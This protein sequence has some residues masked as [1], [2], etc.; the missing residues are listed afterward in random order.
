KVPPFPMADVRRI[1]ELELG[2]QLESVFDPF[3]PVPIAAA[4]LGQVHRAT[5]HG[6]VVAIKVLRPN[7]ER[8]VAA[9]LRIMRFML[10]AARLVYGREV[11]LQNIRNLVSE[12]SRV[13]AAEM[14]FETE[15]ANLA[16]FRTNLAE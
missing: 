13:I 16:E 14:N 5:Y 1:I 10:R 2:R 4:S 7:V 3:D 11:H 6:T 9:D 12:F 8:L 15:A